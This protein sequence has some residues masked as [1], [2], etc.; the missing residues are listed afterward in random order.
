MKSASSSAAGAALLSSESLLSP[1]DPHLEAPLSRWVARLRYTSKASATTS[2]S[3]T[4]TAPGSPDQRR[5][6]TEV[7]LGASQWISC[8]SEGLPG[9]PPPGNTGR[10]ITGLTS[11]HLRGP[12]HRCA[13]SIMSLED[14]CLCAQVFAAAFSTLTKSSGIALAACA[15]NHLSDS[16]E[17]P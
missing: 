8:D 1:P 3:S 12:R 15:L 5:P 13:R 4:C 9:A 7:M 17:S 10:G 14:R 16:V 6:V 11:S 2:T